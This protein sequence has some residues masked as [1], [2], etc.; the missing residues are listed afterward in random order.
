MHFTLVRLTSPHMPDTRVFDDVLLPLKFA[1][2]RLGF[3][4]EVRVNSFNPKSRNICLGANYDPGQKWRVLPAGAII[5]NLE[6]LEASGYPWQ[7]EGSYFDLLKEFESW[8]FSQKNIA[9]L[10]VKGLDS[11]FLPLGYVPEMS[12]LAPCPEPAYDVLF[13]GAIT[14]RRR[15]VLDALDLRGLKVCR[16]GKAFAD[17]RDRAIYESKLLINIH[18]SLPASLEVVRLGYAL[19]NG[20]AVVSE[21]NEDTYHYPELSSACLY[22]KAEELADLAFDL[23]ADDKRRQEVARR[24]FEAYSALRLEKALERIVGS[25]L[26]HGLGADFA[27]Q[28]PAPAAL[29]IGSGERFLAEAVNIDKDSRWRADLAMS[30]PD[31]WSADKSFPSARFGDIVLA[32]A[33]FERI[34]LG[35]LLADNKP[36]DAMLAACH[37]LLSPGGRLILTLPY[38]AEGAGGGSPGF[39]ENSF[40]SYLQAGCFE[41][42]SVDYLWTDLG[43]VL[44]T[45]GLPFQ[46]RLKASGSVFALRLILR[47]AGPFVASG[48]KQPAEIWA[49]KPMQ[50]AMEPWR[51][52]YSRPAQPWLVDDPRDEAGYKPLPPLPPIN[53]MRLRL[54]GLWLK[55]IRYNFNLRYGLSGRHDRYREKLAEVERERQEIRRLLS[56]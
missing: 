27:G 20:R 6:Q 26:V 38:R 53:K 35:R 11:A 18:H 19:A 4:V 12:R 36:P 54:T 16:L 44:E 22:G 48:P 46:K 13:Y 41:R 56:L 50:Q 43:R 17:E 8:D 33:S 40:A 51:F 7:K 5:F 49:E 52:I 28:G 21:M 15:K 32:P 25:R 55:K 23:A 37:E 14:Q 31:D 47:K 9:Y 29:N 42:E 24:G 2:Q 30:F 10:R 39:H 45:R 3:E 1:F 34:F